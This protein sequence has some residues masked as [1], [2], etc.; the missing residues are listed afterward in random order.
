M[1]YPMTDIERQIL[2]AL[3]QL[4]G[5]AKAMKTTGAKPDL[6]SLFANLDKL[7][8][9]LGRDDDP[10]LRHFLQ[11]KS[12]EKARLLLLGR[13]AENTRGACG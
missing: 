11:R 8:G 7:T 1:Q 9:E 3:N 10:E 12:Y 13:G 4:D 6:Q 2:D 5:T